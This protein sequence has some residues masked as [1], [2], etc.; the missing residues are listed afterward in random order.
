MQALFSSF[1]LPEAKADEDQISQEEGVKMFFV[2]SHWQSH[3]PGFCE[4]G[5]NVNEFV[6]VTGW[7]FTPSS[8]RRKAG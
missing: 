6:S 1:K 2:T 4:A 5:V 3:Q 8:H 7:Y